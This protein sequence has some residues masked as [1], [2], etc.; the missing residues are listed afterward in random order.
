MPSIMNLFPLRIEDAFNH[1]LSIM[2]LFSFFQR[3]KREGEGARARARA[4]GTQVDRQMDT[5]CIHLADHVE[6]KPTS[7]RV[8]VRERHNPIFAD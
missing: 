8:C 2:N 6:G 3:E 4:L 7:R 5:P 1:E